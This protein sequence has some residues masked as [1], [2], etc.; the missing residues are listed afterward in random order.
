MEVV[1]AHN[2]A[3]GGRYRPALILMALRHAGLEANVRDAD[4]LLAFARAGEAG[5]VRRPISVHALAASLSVSPETAR[6]VVAT[7]E[8]EGLCR[9]TPGGV[10]AAAHPALPSLDATVAAA[11]DL[12]WRRMRDLGA[13]PL[14]GCAPGGPACGLAAEDRRAAVALA[15]MDYLISVI[16]TTLAAWGEDLLLTWVF[17]AAMAVNA[18]AITTDREL[19]WR[20]AY[21]DTAPPDD[22]R[23]PATV[24]AIAERLGLGHEIVRRTTLRAI[25]AGMLERRRGGYLAPVRAMQEAGMLGRGLDLY[26]RF[27]RL[28][29]L[30]AASGLHP[31]QEP[32]AERAMAAVA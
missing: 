3:L 16:G 23:R 2:R 11:F 13:D 17:F 1:S 8:A 6:R 15:V 9:R 24:R 14:E 21:A 22:L 25:P 27:G 18:E 19:A 7:L 29:A 28:N 12:A 30:L 32:A 5:A 4:H 31:L 10:I 20:Y 26:R